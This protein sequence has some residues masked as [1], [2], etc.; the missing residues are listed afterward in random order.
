MRL[1]AVLFLWQG[2]STVA[3]TDTVN[4]FPYSVVAVFKLLCCMCMLVCTLTVG[5][6]RFFAAIAMLPAIITCTENKTTHKKADIRPKSGINQLTEL[7]VVQLFYELVVRSLATPVCVPKH[8]W[9][10][11]HVQVALSGFS[12]VWLLARKCSGMKG[13]ACM[14]GKCCIKCFKC[15]SRVEFALNIFI[16]HTFLYLAINC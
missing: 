9:A 16:Q 7:K 12:A 2:T 1:R 15:S 8:P 10:W 11:Y 13:S 5:R 3:L 6:W 4:I 14:N